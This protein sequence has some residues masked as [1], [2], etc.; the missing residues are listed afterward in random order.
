MAKSCF[1]LVGSLPDLV[2]IPEMTLGCNC[3]DGRGIA[4]FRYSRKP[5][6]VVKMTP[7]Q[8]EVKKK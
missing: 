2:T 4:F 1:F 6:G 8:G 3:L 7:H 5:V